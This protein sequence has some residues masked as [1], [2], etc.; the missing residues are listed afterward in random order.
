MGIVTIIIAYLEQCLIKKTLK[1]NF[2]ENMYTPLHVVMAEQTLFFCSQGFVT[3]VA[4]NSTWLIYAL[5]K[6]LV[7]LIMDH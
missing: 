6:Y 7:G 3:F 1:Q 4:N 5:Q 2:D